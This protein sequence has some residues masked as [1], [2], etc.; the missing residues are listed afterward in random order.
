MVSFGL[1]LL[2]L[3]SAS[4][5]NV[6]APF[7]LY[8]ELVS[9]WRNITLDHAKCPI[10]SP[11]ATDQE[12]SSETFPSGH[13]ELHHELAPV[14]GY[15]CSGLRYTTE[16]YE[17]FLGGKDIKKTIDKVQVTGD[18][19]LRELE[20][21]KTG[22]VIP[23]YF[24]APECA[25]M[26]TQT[27]D[28]VFYIIE[29]HSVSYDPYKIGFVDPIFLKDICVNKVCPTEH[30]NMLWVTEADVG[31]QCSEFLDAEI[32]FHSN[33]NYSITIIEHQHKMFEDFT[34]ACRMTYCGEKGVR[35]P[36]GLFYT[37]IPPPYWHNINECSVKRNVTF[38]P[39]SA[40][41]LEIERE[42]TVDRERMMC[43][44]SLQTARR[45]KVMTFLTLSYLVPK[46]EGRF[47]VYRLEKGQLKG[48]V[49]NWH[50]LKTVKPGTSRQIGTFPNGT[51]AYWWDWVD[52]GYPGI[53]SGF[54]GVHRTE[55][56]VV[57]PRLEV[58]KKEYALSLDILHE[59]RTI[60]HPI[61]KHLARENLTGHLTTL[62]G[63]DSIDV[64]EWLS[65]LWEK[66]WGKLLLLGCL[67]GFLLVV[68]C[69][70]FGRIRRCLSTTSRQNNDIEMLPLRTNLETVKIDR[71]VHW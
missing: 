28:A 67:C 9:P 56:K 37:H 55:G 22:S 38:Y 57:I 41:L 19:C 33:Q 8:P 43:I 11:V 42:M 30:D 12:L 20:K 17:G 40:E 52:S 24:P 71:P 31:H 10:S 45:T 34:K 58:L 44:E 3:S 2:F 29:E 65:N 70:C 51:N 25:W 27:N 60:E 26:K 23:P 32:T 47:P 68:C 61:I 64:G 14:K 35:L 53:D 7:F 21:V 18:I 50:A 49:A 48:A 5:L 69:C 6:T 62:E 66:I 39:L 59:M 63:R 1:L 4:G 54:N 15:L 13:Q 36:S 46:F 16:C